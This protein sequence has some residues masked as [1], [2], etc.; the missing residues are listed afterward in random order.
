MYKLLGCSNMDAG[1]Q[2][3]EN[4]YLEIFTGDMG[5]QYVDTHGIYHL[6]WYI[7]NYAVH[8]QIFILKYVQVILT[9]ALILF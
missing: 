8:W 7:S 5:R 3:I 4:M 1:H 6:T 2:L 9:A